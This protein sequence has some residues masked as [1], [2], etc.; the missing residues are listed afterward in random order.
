MW[1]ELEEKDLVKAR[2]GGEGKLVR[3]GV[4]SGGQKGCDG[5][6]A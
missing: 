3:G 1:R 6:R 2:E 5:R 4:F